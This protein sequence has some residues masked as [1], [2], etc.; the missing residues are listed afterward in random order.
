MKSRSYLIAIAMSCAVSGAA[1]AAQG[2]AARAPGQTS[3]VN[4]PP[5]PTK[6]EFAQGSTARYRVQE[7]LAGISFP[8]D[9]VGSTQAIKGVVML[10]ADGAVNPA[11]SKI[12]VD[13][14]TISSDQERRDGYVQRNV[15]G[16]D[17]QPILEFVPKRAVGLPS[18][19]PNAERPA[20]VGV[21]LIGDMTLN[22]VTSEVT[23]NLAATASFDA[24]AGRATTSFP[25]S[26]F[27][28]NQ[29]KVSILLSVE[30]KINLE[31]EFRCKR[32]PV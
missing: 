22:G 25:F 27:K 13:L 1:L 8:N 17:K 12:T 16:A 11:Q 4:L 3:T 28:L 14:T 30:D 26:K 2:Q 20:G 21:Q 31:V 24:I 9:A 7:Q 18:P 19:F 29:P 15:L 23:W 10:A 32:T 6:C 5:V